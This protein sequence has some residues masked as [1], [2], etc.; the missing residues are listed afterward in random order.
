MRFCVTF[1]SVNDVIDGG[2]VVDAER[3]PYT[4]EKPGK[5]AIYYPFDKLEVPGMSFTA[6]KSAESLLAAAR[7]YREAGHEEQ[8]FRAR[9]LPAG[10]CRVWRVK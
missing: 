8:S 5:R 3:V 2:G 7:R 9:D 10:G 6:P 4:G 1:A